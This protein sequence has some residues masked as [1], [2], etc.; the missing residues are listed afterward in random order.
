MPPQH[1]TP[2]RWTPFAAAGVVAVVCVLILEIG[3]RVAGLAPP[4][5]LG[6]QAFVA[7]PHLPFKPASRS[8]LA[9]RS[10]TDEFDF[11]YRHDSLGFRDTEHALAKPTGS[12]RI[13]A[14]GDSL[15]YGRRRKTH[16]LQFETG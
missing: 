7:N 10:P 12:F 16:R 9:G 8:R 11:D 4:L 2:S 15:T 14:V 3:V 1:T 6:A 13:V 5:N